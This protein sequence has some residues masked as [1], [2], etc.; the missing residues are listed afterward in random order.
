MKQTFALFGTLLAALAASA[1][2]WIPALLGVGAAGSLGFSAALAPWR[3]HLLVLTGL[4]LAGGFW[5]AYRGPR[6]ACCDSSACG[7]ST[8]QTRRRLNIGV[9]WVVAA[10]ALATAAYPNLSAFRAAGHDGLTQA[11]E[12]PGI[13]TLAFSVEGMDCEA[14]ALPISSEVQKLPGVRSARVDFSKKELRVTAEAGGPSPQAIL[15]AVKQAGFTASPFVS[16]Q[17]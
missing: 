10:F 12:A 13:E 17:Q 3:P 14:C 9:M 5:A 8:A 4:F 1:C 15:A 16:R 2:C 6:K 11:T 7:T